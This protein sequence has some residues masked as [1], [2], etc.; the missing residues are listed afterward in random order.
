MADAKAHVIDDD[1]DARDALAFLLST[2]GVAAETYSSAAAFL[3]VAVEARGVVVTDVRMPEMDGIELARQL[4]ALGVRLPVIVMTGH[5]DIPLAVEAMK[6]GVMDFIEKPY[7]NEAML[8]AIANRMASQDA[9]EARDEEKADFQRRLDRLSGRERQVLDGLI[10]GSPN[11]VIARDLEISPRTV[12]IYRA[13]VMNKMQARSLSELVRI[14][15]MTGT[16]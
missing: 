7:D 2:A 12:E 10:A 11:K 15:L 6:A 13:N 14:A 1:D 8:A 16:V 4:N 5:G 9:Y 3:A